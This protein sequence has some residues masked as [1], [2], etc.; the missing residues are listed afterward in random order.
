MPQAELSTA[1]HF[2]DAL[3]LASDGRRRW[4]SRVDKRYWNAIGPFGGWTVGLLLK[5]VLAEADHA[6]APVAMTANLMG[7]LDET[8]I[9]LETRAVRQGRSMEFWTSELVQN[10]EPAAMA[11]VTLGQRRETLSAHEAVFPQASPPEALKPPERRGGGVPFGA[12]FDMRPVSGPAPFQG[13]G[14][15]SRTVAWVRDA[16]AR[17]L[18]FPLLACLADIFAPRIFYRSREFKPVSTVSMSV[19]FHATP[20]ELAAVGGDWLLAEAQAR[21]FESGFFDQHGALWTRDGTLLATTE[22]LCWFK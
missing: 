17:P 5:A 18:D 11:M 7:G 12:M 14:E 19:Y 8:P 10:G 16:Q 20:A 4:L 13:E 21:R 1:F 22:Q 9:S 3:P 6:G 15:D 2:D